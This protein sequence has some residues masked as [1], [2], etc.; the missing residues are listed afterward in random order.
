MTL[1]Q[2]IETMT[3]EDIQELGRQ[4]EGYASY[5]SHSADKKL[6]LLALYQRS[7][8]KFYDIEEHWRKQIT[9]KKGCAHCC[10]IRAVSTPIEAE[11]AVDYATKNNIPIDTA[12]LEKQ[13]DM[14]VEEYMFSPHRTC[15][16]L[17]ED[18]TCGIYPVRPFA[19]RTYFVI[20]DPDLCD[21]PKHPHYEVCGI[22]SLPMQIPELGLLMAGQELDSF[23]KQLLN[24][25][26]TNK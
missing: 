1:D 14:D 19:C 18:N 16:F 2:F 22:N 6:A 15:V 23:P 24:A 13:K 10:K 7:Q 12:R 3:P 26:K 5:F 4:G 9:C 11:L 17:Q 8:E 25:I 20:S 21:V